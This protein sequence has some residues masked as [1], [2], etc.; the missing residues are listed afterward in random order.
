MHQWKQY[1]AVITAAITI[2]I[3]D[4]FHASCISGQKGITVQ[5]STATLSE[6]WSE[7]RSS[8]FS[9]LTDKTN[10]GS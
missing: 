7:L 3:L 6:S 2:Y 8:I 10:L 5:Q 4:V 1:E 9:P